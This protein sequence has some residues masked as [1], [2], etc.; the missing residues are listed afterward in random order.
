VQAPIAERVLSLNPN[1]K[2]AYQRRGD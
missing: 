2:G 1:K